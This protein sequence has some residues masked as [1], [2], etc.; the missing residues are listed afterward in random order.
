MTRYGGGIKRSSQLTFRRRLLLVRLLLR[1]PATAE[2][3]IEA[4]QRE[5]GTEGYPAA[6]QV[7]LR[8]DIKALKT[9]YGCRI[10]LRRDVGG[11][12]LEDLGELALL[13]L[14]DEALEAF[15][16]LDASF[17]PGAAIPELANVRQLLD[18]VLR[19][20]P[21]ERQ[22]EQRRRRSAPRL[23]LPAQPESRVDPGV[24]RTVKRAINERRELRFLYWSTFDIDAPRQHRVAPYGIFFRP[25]GHTCLDATLLEVKPVGGETIHAAIDYRLDRIVPGSVKVLP[26]ML[27]PERIVPRFYSL[28]YHLLP[29]VARRRDVAA[30]FPNTQIEYH[31]DGS[32]TVTATVTN[33]WQARQVLLRYGDACTV[34]SPPELIEMFRR[35]AQGL[36]EKYGSA[37]EG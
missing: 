7:A 18:Q 4:I 20:L 3:L 24:L 8:H 37:T 16:F 23:Q 1:G 12:V 9:E 17:P 6:A 19:L 14:S 30:Y 15:S 33:L 13:D 36:W 2:E 29:V 10:T 32:A 5:L 34:L 28:R 22:E 35:T 11:Y 26:T 31:D 25:E 21:V 27:P